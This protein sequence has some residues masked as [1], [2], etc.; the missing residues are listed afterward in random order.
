MQFNLTQVPLNADPKS[1]VTNPAWIRFFLSLA[2]I[3]SGIGGMVYPEFYG[4]IGDGITDDTAAFASMMLSGAHRMELTPGATYLL[5]SVNLPTTSNFILEGNGAIIIPNG[6]VASPVVNCFFLHTV[7]GWTANYKIQNIRIGNDATHGYVTDFISIL[8]D[9]GIISTFNVNHIYAQGGIGTSVVCFE[10]N[11]AFSPEQINFSQIN[12]W[13]GGLFFHAVRL[14]AG[15]G[16]TQPMGS[17]HMKDIYQWTNGANWT[18]ITSALPIE[19]SDFTNIFSP[20]GAVIDFIDG[21]HDWSNFATATR[22][23]TF[24]NIYHESGYANGRTIKG[25]FFNCDFKNINLLDNNTGGEIFNG[26]MINCRLS[27]LY[28]DRPAG[29]GIYALEFDQYS[30]Y[31]YINDIWNVNTGAIDFTLINDTGTHNIHPTY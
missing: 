14:V 26:H 2:N 19:R 24:T 4:A 7:S 25:F 20:G 22:G 29:S 1:L 27:D 9:G 5:G 15:S 23:C 18:A 8:M 21:G 11:Q 28:Y 30:N 10:L 16:I 17:M 13:N 12:P 6:T 3:S 31:N